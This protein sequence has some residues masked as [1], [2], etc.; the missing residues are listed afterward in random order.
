MESDL[1]SSLQAAR[2]AP[3]QQS[4]LLAVLKK[5]QE[6]DTAMAETVAQAT[7]PAPPPDGQGLKV[8]KLA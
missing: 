8:D 1:V 6:L 4:A 5:N 3:G 2:T 7:R